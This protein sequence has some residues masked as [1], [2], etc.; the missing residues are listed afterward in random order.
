M[1]RKVLPEYPSLPISGRR[2]SS[3]LSILWH[4]AEFKKQKIEEKASLGK[5]TSYLK[6]EV[7][8]LEWVIQHVIELEED[9]NSKEIYIK[10]HLSPAPE[11]DQSDS[12]A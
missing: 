7:S 4:E 11:S 10:E 12:V 6:K 8:A 5:E 3:K 9:L 2:G 1:S